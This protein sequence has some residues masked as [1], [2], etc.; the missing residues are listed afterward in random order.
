M[1]AAL[2]RQPRRVEWWQQ[3]HERWRCRPEH[4]DEDTL[5]NAGA[6]GAQLRL[7]SEGPGRNQR[8]MGLSAGVSHGGEEGEKR[9]WLGRQ[10]PLPVN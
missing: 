2:P 7:D 10:V 1:R 5:G 6:G 8:Q 4:S 9:A 3:Q